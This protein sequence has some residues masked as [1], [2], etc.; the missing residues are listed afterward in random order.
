MKLDVIKET[1][2][3]HG[4]EFFGIAKLG[5]DELN[6][7]RFKSWLSESR[8]GSMS[9]IEKYPH[10]R[11]D[12][13][14]IDP[15]AAWAILIGVP[16]F[17]G[18]RMVFAP[19]NQPEKL[20]QSRVF[21]Q[22]LGEQIDRKNQDSSSHLN[23][24]LLSIKNEPSEKG[25]DST[26]FFP[27]IPATAPRPRVAQYARFQDYHSYTKKVGEVISRELSKSL[28]TSG[29]TFWRAVSDSI[30]F[31]ERAIHQRFSPA[32]IGKNTMLI[33]PKKGSYFLL[34]EILTD[35]ALFETT[36]E[37]KTLA[38][39]ESGG[40]GGCRRCQVYCPT[41]A[42]DVDYQIDAKRCLSYL[43][44]EHRGEIEL[45]YWKHFKKYWYGCD[46]CQLVCPYNR[47][48]EPK[49]PM[50]SRPDVEKDLA[51]VAVM[52]QREYEDWFGGT[53]MTRAK[54]NGLR[55][56]AVIAMAASKDP[57]VD[58]IIEQLRLDEDPV[59]RLTVAAIP[60]FLKE[61][62]HEDT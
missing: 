30:P 42:L 35:L 33:H 14:Q 43:T 15:K 11:R 52:S 40:C 6:F 51:Q 2:E 61:F 45:K 16:Y 62:F 60:A 41:G 3:S 7:D 19:K 44:I 36:P 53:P 56:N 27:Q 18:D 26:V 34:M 20:S 22:G 32:F 4:L 5:V 50:H 55:R 9:W 1:I 38:R 8:H 49:S 21:W 37:I 31:L 10:I 25:S 17:C 57:R 29:S 28:D 13:S 59:I 54:R 58:R 24:D 48:S 39:S 23:N 47:N 12:P 46:I